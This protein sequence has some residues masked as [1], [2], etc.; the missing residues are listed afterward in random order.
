MYG[1]LL[2]IAT[3]LALPA[4]PR[5]D[6]APK[7]ALCPVCEIR[8]ETEEEKVK[9]RAE[10]D[11]NAYYFC[12]KSCREEFEADPIAFIPPPLP[13]GAPA[14]SVETLDGEPVD[15]STHYGKLI[16]LDFWAT[17]CK[18][19]VDLM[20]SLQGIH[21]RYADRGLV[22]VG[23]SIDEG[24]D[25]IKK[26]RKFVERVGVDYSIY[27]DARPIPA[28]HTFKVKAIPALFLIDRDRQI[29]AQWLGTIDHQSL[30][31]VIQAHLPP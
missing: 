4:T 15:L 23:I 29:V 18:P 8:G 9:A 22:V 6:Q 12:S 7:K 30:E 1:I 14:F 24:K 28:W 13:R 25:R 31:S 17:W 3:I 5:A 2:F 20:P 21:E 27:S 19:C 11:G 26:I 16:V 10:H